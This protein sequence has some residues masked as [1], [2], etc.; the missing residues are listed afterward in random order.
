MLEAYK[1]F[2]N[3][4]TNKI[5]IQTKINNHTLEITDIKYKNKIKNDEFETK[6]SWIYDTITTHDAIYQ[7]LPIKGRLTEIYKGLAIIEKKNNPE[8]IY[9]FVCA[10]CPQTKTI[11]VSIVD[12]NNKV[13]KIRGSHKIKL[14]FFSGLSST[15]I[16]HSNIYNIQSDNNSNCICR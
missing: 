10:Y 1:L 2:S 9:N 7:I 3:K 4:K 8:L 13:I 15:K 5:K 16:P 6:I 11:T 12:S 14:Y